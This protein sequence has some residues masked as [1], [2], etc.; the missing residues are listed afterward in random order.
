MSGGAS[1]VIPVK[2]GARYLEEVLAA[3][4]AQ[5]P[6]VE[7]LVIDSGSGDGSPAI[8]RAA[9]VELLQ[10]EPA[11]FGHGRTRNLGAERTSG[12]LICF[13]TQDA[14]PLP[15]WLAAFREAL[16]LEERV[17]AAFGPHLP[18][19]DTSPMI[20]RELTEFF[21]GFSPTGGPALQHRGGEPFLSNVNA[22]YRRDCWEEVR[23]DD[24]A[25][26]EDQ[27]F[28]RAMLA[29]GWAKAYHPDAAVLH[30][31]DY[32]PVDFMRRY[33][34]EYRGLRESS[35]HVEGFGLRSA[36]RDVQA[37]VAADRRWMEERG[38]A[39]GAR[40]RWTARS[41][42]HHAG[43]KVFSALGS[44]A[45]RLPAAAQRAISLE[46]RTSA[47]PAEARGGRAPV[48]RDARGPDVWGDVTALKRLGEAPLLEP[49]P[50]MA[51]AERLH[52]AVVIPHFRRGSGGHSTIY[53]LLTR[54]EDRGHLVSTWLHD[55]VGYMKE[56]PAAVVRGDLREW[57]R[58]PRG[59][60][61]KGFGQW[62]GA[63]VVLATGW[64]TVSPVLRLDQARARA[65]LVQDHEPEF[66]AT[67]AEALWARETYT[68]GL[69]CITAGP[70]LRDLLATRYGATAS[71]F[72]LGVDHDVYRPRP[73]TRRED[74]IVFYA[75]HV[76][77]RR[78][79]PLGL[80]ALAEVHRR[81]PHTRF[82]LFGDTQLEAP[83][84]YEELGIATP[85][86]LAWAYSEATVGLSISLTN[87]SLIPQEMMA[88]DL[89]VV[90]IAG[91]N[92]ERVFGADGPARL[93]APDPLELADALLALLD[94]DAE[95]ARR[96]AAGRAFVADKTWDHAADQLEAGLRDALRARVAPLAVRDAHPAGAAGDRNA[97]T[98]A[99]AQ[100]GRRPA[101]ERLFAR[102]DED[103]V[104]AVRERL[105][106]EQAWQWEHQP[107]TRQ[108]ALLFGVWHAVPS[109]IEKTGL[110]PAAPPEEVHAMARGPLAAGGALYDADLV[111]EAL[112]RAGADIGDARRGLDFGCSSGRLVR[113]LDAAWPQTEWHGCDPNADAIAWA[114]DHL[115]G[116][117]FDRSPLEPPL[118]YDDGAFDVACA[119]SIW[120]HYGEQ[121]AQA[122]LGELHRVLRPGGRLVLT[123]HGMQS[124]AYYARTGRRA[125]AELDRVR[126]ALYRTGFFFLDEFGPDGDWGV[127]HP[128]WGTS[129]F[130]P[131]WLIARAVP[132]WSV[133]DYAVGRNAD[134]QD[135]YVLRRR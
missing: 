24:V 13:L 14:T 19:P 79:V 100:P 11:S 120:S 85:E 116:I 109:V 82:V 36:A 73:V 25:Y 58:P 28:G 80:Q 98:V 17:G 74:T 42:V 45:E 111:A 129:F 114:R 23:F 122:W 6:G 115:P 56:Y 9:G 71:S 118:P 15:G 39:P 75:R 16:A 7:V 112:A 2:D 132:A 90:E 29:A 66:F 113:A 8:A 93:A 77:P 96:T 88:C 31:H 127:R 104:A 107:D 50:G 117:A 5:E 130:T 83:F 51:D 4:L 126:A 123:A 63:D 92:L 72:D 21:A 70:W 87:Y 32:P 33:F 131:E 68:S 94:D 108:L 18:R 119:I 106:E 57:F 121:A 133:E 53:N 35:G 49:V 59:P 41:T 135:V 43:R 69:H 20:A 62:H 128:Q 27:A 125:A 81:R 65:Y 10:I 40:A 60:V 47:G 38:I 105:D 54:L 124:V 110:S 78:G 102:L 46:G 95:R 30:A 97:R 103:D 3:V 67:S 99:A 48:H 76:T 22:C 64:D 52:V 101:T 89:P 26:S 134:N 37:L 61:F 34:D 86:E 44:R 55:P 1:V 91:D 12:E 84:P